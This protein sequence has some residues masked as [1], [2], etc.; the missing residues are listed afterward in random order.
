M[1]TH[2]KLWLTSISP[3]DAHA[4]EAALLCVR[5][6][7]I[8]YDGTMVPTSSGAYT[9]PPMYI[10][11]FCYYYYYYYSVENRLCALCN[12]HSDIFVMCKRTKYPKIKYIY[13]KRANRVKEK[14]K[15]NKSLRIFKHIVCVYFSSLLWFSE[16]WRGKAKR[17][18]R[19]KRKEERKKK[20]ENDDDD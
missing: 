15:K 18:G 16:Y 6:I 3:Y 4:N 9:I 2:T 20:N 10:Y 19:E 14:K 12:A 1:R 7:S 17:S 13:S 8:L 5:I 11:L